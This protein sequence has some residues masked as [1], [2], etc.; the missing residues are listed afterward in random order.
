MFPWVPS[1]PQW[2]KFCGTLGGA[3][4]SAFAGTLP[5]ELQPLGF[6]AG[7]TLALLSFI[8]LVWH[9]LN[10]RRQARG[11]PKMTLEPIH[12]VAVG[13][14]IVLGGAAWQIYSSKASDGS[15]S[16]DRAHFVGTVGD[17]YLF[18]SGTLLGSGSLGD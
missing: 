4:M 10:E 12:A 6:I 15:S 9:W 7:V 8:G 3:F 2:V 13:A 14:L 17:P 18:G 1:I 11:K 5:S 16:G